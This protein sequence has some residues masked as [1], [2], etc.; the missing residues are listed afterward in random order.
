MSAR[1]RGGRGGRGGQTKSFTKE[2]LNALGAATNEVPGLV[3]QPPALYPVI[4]KRPIPVTVSF[5]F[6]CFILRHQVGYL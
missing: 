3:T 6:L 2:Q 4:D 1:G 5:T